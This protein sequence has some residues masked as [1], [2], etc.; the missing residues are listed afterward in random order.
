MRNLLPAYRPSLLSEALADAAEY[1]QFK[2]NFVQEL[3]KQKEELLSRQIPLTFELLDE[4]YKTPNHS[5]IRNNY[6]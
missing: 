2:C 5:N 6:E 1:K 4:S 3:L